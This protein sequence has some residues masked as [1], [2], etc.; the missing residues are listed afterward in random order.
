MRV[1]PSSPSMT[2]VACVSSDVAAET[3]EDEAAED[4]TSDLV[5]GSEA[6]DAA[7][8]SFGLAADRPALARTS[9]EGVVSRKT[10]GS[11]APWVGWSE[12][13][14]TFQCA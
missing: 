10:L 3:P 4:E 12:T 7:T 9:G 1:L 8:G 6:V 11:G 13:G 2:E 14:S 5:S